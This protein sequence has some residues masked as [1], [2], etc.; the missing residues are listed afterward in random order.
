M[1]KI[2][3]SGTTP[4]PRP[5]LVGARADL[6]VY[7][8]RHVHDLPSVGVCREQVAKTLQNAW[9]PRPERPLETVDKLSLIHI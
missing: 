5:P 7:V 9:P 3:W 2:D 4:L 6:I 8:R 1:V